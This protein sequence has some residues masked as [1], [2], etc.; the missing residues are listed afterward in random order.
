MV[1]DW[2]SSDDTEVEL[3]ELAEA[4]GEDTSALADDFN[5]MYSVT[6]Q[7]G[8]VADAVAAALRCG[9][10][11]E[12]V[13]EMMMIIEEVSQFFGPKDEFIFRSMEDLRASLITILASLQNRPDMMIAA[14]LKARPR[15]EWPDVLEK[16]EKMIQW[17]RAKLDETTNYTMGGVSD[18]DRP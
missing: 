18:D 10:D 16:L 15:N 8:V 12:V 13:R 3:D 2:G 1:A 14:M 5:T 7:S 6:N 17:H 4:L 9:I 11:D